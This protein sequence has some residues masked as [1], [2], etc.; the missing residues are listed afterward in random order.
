MKKYLFVLLLAALF[1]GCGLSVPTDKSS[2][3]SGDPVLQV[4]NPKTQSQVVYLIGA[5][6]FTV[7][8]EIIYHDG[9]I[10]FTDVNDRSI[11]WGGDVL[12][13]DK[14]FPRQKR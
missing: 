6:D 10:K 11:V 4:V 3:L 9:Y 2:E 8:G 12:I 1:V 5:G 7:K 13:T 14:P